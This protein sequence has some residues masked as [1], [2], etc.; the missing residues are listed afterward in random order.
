MKD[1]SQRI[2]LIFMLL[3]ICLTTGCA[4]IAV[5]TKLAPIEPPRPSFQPRVE[6]TV[7]DFSFKLEGGAIATSKFTGRL[8]NYNILSSWK[9]RGYICDERYIESGSF[10]RTADYNLTLSGS[11]YGKS[12]IIMQ[13]LSGL[14]LTLLPY[15]VTTEWDIRYTVEDVK[16][17]K[18][19]SASVQ[20]SYESYVELFLVF[21][22]P[23]ATR[24]YR[25]TIQRIGDHLYNE[26]YSQGAFQQSAAAA[27]ESPGKK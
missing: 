19:Y 5:G 22:F 21:T 10:S 8:L 24:N 9:R 4:Y 1:P 20:E 14:T 16:N 15:T 7:G 6:H 3:G 13:I 26:L 27:G 11:Q 2:L 18:N 25:E 23:V 17:G 12:S